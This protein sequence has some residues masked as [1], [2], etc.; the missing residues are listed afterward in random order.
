MTTIKKG[1]ETQKNKLCRTPIAV[2]PI[3]YYNVLRNAFI[4]YEWK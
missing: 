2:Q 4:V 1:G 3:Q